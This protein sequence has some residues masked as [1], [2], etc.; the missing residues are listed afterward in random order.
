M[1][2]PR[3]GAKFRQPPTVGNGPTA[4]TYL[5]RPPDMASARMAVPVSRHESRPR[6]WTCYIARF[7]ISRTRHR[8]SLQVSGLAWSVH[9]GANPDP[10][11]WSACRA[12][13]TMRDASVTLHT[14]DRRN[15]IVDA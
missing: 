4:H 8:G 14:F 15:P 3:A 5:V 2:M 12:V 7:L 11:T 10:T 13:R 9:L 6:F 1:E